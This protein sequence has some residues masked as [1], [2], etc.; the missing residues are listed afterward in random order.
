LTSLVSTLA[1]VS[2]NPVS[3]LCFQILN[4]HRYVTGEA[5]R[6]VLA[7]VI[8]V[9]MPG[10]NLVFFTLAGTALHL[11]SVFNSVGFS[12]TFCRHV[13]KTNICNVVAR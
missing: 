4:S 3:S 10:I 12:H 7:A 2:A 8:H 11:S 1:P 5:E 9:V 13:T 6:E